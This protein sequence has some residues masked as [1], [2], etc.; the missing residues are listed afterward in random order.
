MWFIYELLFRITDE[1]VLLGVA[2][3]QFK[4]K[5]QAYVEGVKKGNRIMKPYERVLK[6]GDEGELVAFVDAL[7][8]H[9]HLENNLLFPRFEEI[10]RKIVF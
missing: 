5:H 3:K 2:K 1:L 8:E 7:F 4:I 6:L 9:I 10:E